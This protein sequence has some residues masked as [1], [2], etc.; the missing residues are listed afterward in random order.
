MSLQSL[1]P[2]DAYLT[3]AA[4]VA[5]SQRLKAAGN[6]AAFIAEVSAMNLIPSPP[7]GPTQP[8]SDTSGQA[9]RWSGMDWR[10]GGEDRSD[11]GVNTA[12]A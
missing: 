8:A 10:D 7:G 11:H 12:G 9:S 6:Q 4:D 3:V 1:P 2:L 5:K